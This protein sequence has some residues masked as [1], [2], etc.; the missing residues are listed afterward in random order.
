MVTLA[1][2]AGVSAACAEKVLRTIQRFDPIG[3]GARDLREC[4]LVQAHWFLTEG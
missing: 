3:C 2:E 1:L 4:L